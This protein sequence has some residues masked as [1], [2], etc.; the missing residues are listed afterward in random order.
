MAQIISIYG[1]VASVIISNDLVE[2]MPLHTAFL[3]LGAGL[4]VGLCGLAAGFA[5]GIIGDAGVRAST[6]QPRLYVGMVLILIFAEVL[7]LYGVIV[8]ILMLTRSRLDVTMC[9]Y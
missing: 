7:G 8:S 9:P 3:Q 1:L 4:A 2:K 6:Q 5:I